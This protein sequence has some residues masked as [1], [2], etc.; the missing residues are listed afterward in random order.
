VDTVD[1]EERGGELRPAALRKTR[2]Y[3]EGRGDVSKNTMMK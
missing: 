2:N 1:W 3:M